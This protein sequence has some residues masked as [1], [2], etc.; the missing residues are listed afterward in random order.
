MV[1][2]LIT[3]ICCL[4]I[5]AATLAVPQVNAQDSSG[6][7]LVSEQ[8]LPDSRDAKFP[9]VA[10]GRG[11]SYVSGNANRSDAFFWA[12]RDS[13]TAFGNPLR[14]GDAQGQPDYSPTAITMGADGVA[15]YAWVNQPE[16]K[17]YMRLREANG[18]WSGRRVVDSGSP[19]PIFVEI[20]VASDN[21]LFVA[22]LD[23][24]GPVRYRRSTDRGATWGARTDLPSSP[25]GSQ[26]D[27]ATGPNKT[28]GITWTGSEGGRLQ[29]FVGLWNGSSFV[30]KRV[31][32][33][34]G[35]YANPS[36]TFDTIGTAYVAWRGVADSGDKAGAF[37][38]E[39]KADDSWPSSKLA[40]G[41]VTGKV[42]VDS[43][44]NGNLH[45]AWIGQPSGGHQVYYA[46]KPQ[47][48]RPRGPV[49]GSTRGA[50][51][52]P[53]AAASDYEGPYAHVVFEDFTGSY[54][55]AR[56]ALFQ[57][58][59]ST[60]GAD[61]V[62]EG[63]ASVVGGK[64]TVAV[65]FANA[66]GLTGNVQIRWRWNAAPTDSADDSGGW[67]TFANPLTIPIPTSI[68]QGG[69]C[70]PSTLYTQIRNLTTNQLE[71]TAK[72]DTIVVDG[73][74]Q[75]LGEAVNPVIYIPSA[76]TVPSGLEAELN[77]TAGATGGGHP[78][79]TRIPMLY[80][81]VANQGECSGITSVGVGK[82]AGSIEMTFKADT[83][84]NYGGFIPMPDLTNVK[85][86]ANPVT[87][88][89]RDGANNVRNYD[90]N[91]ILDEDKP[92]LVSSAADSITTAPYSEAD[93]FQ[94][95]SFKNISVT[96]T[97]YGGR[98]FWGVWI[99][100]SRTPV[101]DPA[102]SPDLKWAP[103]AAPGTASE[104]TI[105]GWNLSRGLTRSQVT[106]GQYYIYVRF[107]DGAGNATD[108]VISTT[109]TSQARMLHSY[110]SMLRN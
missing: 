99:A 68:L 78:L 34:G 55:R 51:F 40:G 13:A 105:T 12:K 11:M 85:A 79:Y 84:G 91:I 35:D 30:I 48:D 75:A 49:G 32:T 89:L 7:R 37:Y 54:L 2:Y 95:L 103:V 60:F 70:S 104:F 29:I 67:Q 14:L 9:H 61:P 57:S 98:G 58:S 47:G 94:N 106:P 19:F 15:Y 42:T 87:V 110:L 31:T 96:D 18:T 53:E 33:L 88:Q 56:Y 21:T 24:D 50:I 97:T 77:A 63:G 46:F 71:R 5:L 26:I 23:P 39:H 17:I 74:V 28:V 8:I 83:S 25:I 10:A 73:V 81:H 66:R 20:G 64:N 38:A 3:G 43:D 1:R 69:S 44:E 90:Y 108:N 82:N 65:T 92:V 52:N 102:N 6:L 101:A 72:S 27:I 22:W 4:A 62:I 93:L 59:G 107:L 76:A 45:F 80:L 86:G 109:L 36:I 100:N 16:R 41:G